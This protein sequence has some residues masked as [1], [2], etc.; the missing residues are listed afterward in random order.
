MH[1]LLLLQILR[2][3]Q[4]IFTPWWGRPVAAGQPVDASSELIVEAVRRAAGLDAG[5]RITEF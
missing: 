3:V 4:T 5:I 2:T 1:M